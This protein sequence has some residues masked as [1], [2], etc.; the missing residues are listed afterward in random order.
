MSQGRPYAPAMTPQNLTIHATDAAHILAVASAAQAA[1]AAALA[2][3]TTPAGGPAGDD[4]TWPD[5]WRQGWHVIELCER[6]AE[7][8]ARRGRC[9]APADLD[10]ALAAPPTGTC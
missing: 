9:L 1:C 8:A 10:P 5:W 7:L 4:D 3:Y 6:A 2:E